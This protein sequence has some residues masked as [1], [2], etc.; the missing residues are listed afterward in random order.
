VVGQAFEFGFEVALLL[1]K[2]TLTIGNQV[3]KVPELRPIHGRIV[4]FGDDAI[5]K[6]KPNAAGRCVCG[7]YTIFASVGPSGMNSGTPES[8]IFIV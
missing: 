8:P 1:M 3:L 2:K 5:P 7:S 4:N 6:C